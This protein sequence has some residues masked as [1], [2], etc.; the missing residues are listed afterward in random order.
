MIRWETGGVEEVPK[1]AIDFRYPPGHI[2][3]IDDPQVDATPEI[4]AQVMEVEQ[5]EVIHDEVD[6]EEH[7]EEDVDM[8]EA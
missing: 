5:E 6:V 4:P 2:P 1:N 8:V 7:Y 3:E